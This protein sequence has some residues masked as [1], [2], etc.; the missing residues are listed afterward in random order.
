[1]WNVVHES[2]CLPVYFLLA[3]I[4]PV[5]YFLAIQRFYLQALV[6]FLAKFFP[7]GIAVFDAVDPFIKVLLDTFWRLADLVPREIELRS[8][9]PW[10][11]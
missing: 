7:I 9:N 10:P 2:T 4:L 6:G 1:M 3:L 8:K 11:G 5:I